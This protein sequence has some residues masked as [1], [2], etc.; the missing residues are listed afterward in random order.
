MYTKYIPLKCKFISRRYNT[1]LWEARFQGIRKG[2]I[3]GLGMGAA[4]IVL[5][6]SYA[7]GFWYGAKLVREESHWYTPGRLLVVSNPSL[8][9]KY[10]KL[11]LIRRVAFFIYG[12]L[13]VGS[14]YMNI[15][16][17][18]YYIYLLGV[19]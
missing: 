11:H 15:R 14:L 12:V 19:L 16:L 9:Q 7:L 8:M 5:Y 13:L 18:A 6:G 4:W 10:Y 2:M 3:L 17:S 1:N